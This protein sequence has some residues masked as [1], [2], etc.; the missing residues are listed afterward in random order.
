MLRVPYTPYKEK[1]TLGCQYLPEDGSGTILRGGLIDICRS[2]M[3]NKLVEL[4]QPS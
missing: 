4:A 1:K 2:Q 3:L